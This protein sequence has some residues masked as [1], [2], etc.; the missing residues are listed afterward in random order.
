MNIH[1]KNA[2]IFAPGGDGLIQH[3]DLFIK[4]GKITYNGTGEF[5]RVIDLGGN[6]VLP[7]FKNAHAHSP[8]TFLRSVADDLPLSDWL[9]KL[10]FPMEK[11]LRDDDIYHL[12]NL[13]ILEYLSSGI[14]A[15]FDMYMR[16][17][18]MAQSAIDNGFRLVL[19][20]S[21]N[22]F[23][24]NAQTLKE[25]YVK[26]NGIHPLI[27]YQLGFHAEY[28]TSMELLR[29]I[30]AV[31]YTHLCTGLRPLSC[32]GRRFRIR[33]ARSDIQGKRYY[34]AALS[35]HRRKPSYSQCGGLR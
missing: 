15:A 17:D 28:T 16:P 2:R 27:T 25:E 24:G 4:D 6:L 20:G 30:A 12:T 33:P 5:D 35:A 1:L 21:V 18:L 3:G 29:S 11:K 34:L 10:V 19:C 9:N 31:S 8:M 26:F 23:G 13:A 7:G 32:K 22:D 14:T